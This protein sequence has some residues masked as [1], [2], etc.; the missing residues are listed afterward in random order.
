M[1][2]L[3]GFG[4]FRR[5]VVGAQAYPPIY[6]H[7]VFNN[8]TA[9]FSRIAAA[10][11]A[12]LLATIALAQL[13][14]TV[15]QVS[16]PGPVTNV[17]INFSIYLPEGYSTDLAVSYPVVY[18]LHGLNGT[19][20]GPQLNL[21]PSAFEAAHA[22]GLFGKAIIVFPNGH[23]NSMW[24]DSH[25]M[26]KPAETNFIQELIPY[27]DANYRTLAERQHRFVQGFSMGGYGAVLYFAKHPTLFCKAVSYDGA[28]HNWPTLVANRPD[29]AE[30]IFDNDEAYFNTSGSP[31]TYLE[32]NAALWQ[33][34][35]ALS[36]V[37]GDLADFNSTLHDSLNTWG[38]LHRYA[39]TAC[40]HI[41]PCV[42]NNES[43]TS[44]ALFQQCAELTVGVE[45]PI[46]ASLLSVHPNP[47][48]G[49]IFV[50]VPGMDPVR[51]MVLSSTGQLLLEH[52]V[53]GPTPLDVSALPAG[54]Y[55]IRMEGGGEV[56]RFVKQ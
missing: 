29:I 16:F 12:L 32:A 25:D 22:A 8:V 45:S 38:V 6:L 9:V 14:G 35:T 28:L 51:I 52:L 43:S 10:C 54:V 56:S 47:S 44:A 48:E 55:L 36:V 18:H 13:N 49:Q 17:P 19:H 34:D 11:V 24:A 1:H 42:L 33:S 3:E 2:S 40:G 26:L 5:K 31:W 7:T 50:E 53:Q 39:L 23:G 21:V 46:E 15:Q 20:V 27:V 30:E 41:L 37:V 4:P